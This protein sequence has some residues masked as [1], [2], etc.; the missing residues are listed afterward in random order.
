M[1]KITEGN[2]EGFFNRLSESKA[3]F[4]HCIVLHTPSPGGGIIPWP[5]DPI[6]KPCF[7]PLTPKIQDATFVNMAL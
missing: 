3:H 1:T 2:S 5:H 6:N 7:T 4:F